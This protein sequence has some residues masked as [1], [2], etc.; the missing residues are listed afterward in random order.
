M[1]LNN[2]GFAITTVLYGTLVLFLLLITSMLGMLSL[3]KDRMK[4]LE[5]GAKE[6]INNANIKVD[7]SCTIIQDNITQ[8]LISGRNYG[9]ELTLKVNFENPDYISSYYWND[10]NKN[11]ETLTITSIGTY[12]VNFKD[13]FG[14]EGSCSVDVASTNENGIRTCNVFSGWSSSL[15]Y[16][17]YDDVS[18]PTKAQAE[19]SNYCFGYDYN[20]KGTVTECTAKFGSNLC[21]VYTYSSRTCTN[22]GEFI[23]NRTGESTCNGVNKGTRK[24]LYIKP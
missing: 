14:E 16:Y 9:T 8:Y 19:S 17:Q 11:T 1:K 18:A 10:N 24:L 2:K 3:N 13:T 23:W 21:F 20:R 7:N 4:K 22:W 12:Y 6:I 15:E 5:S